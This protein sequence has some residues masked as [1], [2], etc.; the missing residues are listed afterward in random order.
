MGPVS[1][2]PRLRCHWSSA[3]LLTP[4]SAISRVFG[5]VCGHQSLPL[6]C[7][8]LPPFLSLLLISCQQ[9]GEESPTSQPVASENQPA[10]GSARLR[11]C[12]RGAFVVPTQEGAREAGRRPGLGLAAG[13]SAS[14][15][16]QQSSS[17][18]LLS[19]FCS[20]C[21]WIVTETMATG[22]GP[23][24]A[25][26][27]YLCGCRDVLGDAPQAGGAALHRQAVAA[28]GSGT[29]RR[30]SGRRT[31]TQQEDGEQADQQSR[32]HVQRRT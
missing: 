24:R 7:S 22:A 25:Q 14:A 20:C 13:A 17:W 15:G 28:A 5:R 32:H 3:L 8:A 10:A 16:S 30:R 11:R 2:R 12:C 29:G 9:S 31:E 27:T 6:R 1:L 4:T 26:S 19:V 21:C 18:G 23:G